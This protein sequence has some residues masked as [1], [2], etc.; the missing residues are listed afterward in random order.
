MRLM[1]LG[2][3]E[4]TLREALEVVVLV[5]SVQVIDAQVNT[6]QDLLQIGI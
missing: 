6:L 5:L 2:L 1:A 4:D 3:E